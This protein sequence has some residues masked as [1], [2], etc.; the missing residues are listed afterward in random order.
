MLDYYDVSGC[1]IIRPWGYAIWELIVEFL[2]REMEKIGMEN[3]IFPSLITQMA[4]EK[5]A[6]HLAG[7]KPEVAW[8]TKA[9]D[10]TLEAPLAIRPTSETAMYPAFARWIQS[11]NH[12]PLKYNQVVNAVV[13]TFLSLPN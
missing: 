2:N 8:V 6:S 1:Y 3:C 7:F 11:R 13:V 5:E 9:G 12:L 4:L 10:S